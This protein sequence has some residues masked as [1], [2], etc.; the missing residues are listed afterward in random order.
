MGLDG[1]LH[2]V[3]V[4]GAMAWV[5]GGLTLV[6]LGLR[7]RSKSDSKA[8][9]AFVDALPFVGLRVLAPATFI[10]PITG[11]W[12]V[13]ENASWH[14]SQFWVL[15]GIGLFLLAFVIGALYVGRIGIQLSR[16]VGGDSVD[17]AHALALVNRWLLGYGAVL[18]VLEVAVWDMVFKP[19]T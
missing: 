9:A 6:V 12:M 11:I 14:F 3:H 4:L 10:V 7:T 8:V 5:G 15:L 16:S 19:G 18:A 2:F 17:S 1:W 13:L